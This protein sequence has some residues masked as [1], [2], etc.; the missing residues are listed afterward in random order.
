[1]Q[2]RSQ[3]E[4]KIF[5]VTDTTLPEGRA[6][7]LQIDLYSMLQIDLLQIAPGQVRKEPLHLQVIV[8]ETAGRPLP[9]AEQRSE[10]P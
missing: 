6:R 7:L 3:Q 1:M 5:Q 9:R 10:E 2:T 4:I 8:A